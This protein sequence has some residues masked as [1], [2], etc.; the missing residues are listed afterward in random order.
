MPRQCEPLIPSLSY[1]I[2]SISR[3]FAV[4]FF[5]FSLLLFFLLLLSS[6][7][8]LSCSIDIAVVMNTGQLLSGRSVDMRLNL[9]RQIYIKS[10]AFICDIISSI[11]FALIIMCIQ[12]R[13]TSIAPKTSLHDHNHQTASVSTGAAEFMQPPL[14]RAR[15]ISLLYVARIVKVPRLVNR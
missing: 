13:D 12:V 7:F 15:C 5:S 10:L 11:P 4:F 14:A 2:H 3:S 9:S 1:D 8:S 6:S